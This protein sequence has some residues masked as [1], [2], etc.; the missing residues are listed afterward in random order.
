M[1]MLLALAPFAIAGSILPT[2][3]IMVTTLLGTSRPVT[4]AAAFI[5]G[6]VA[7]RT[8]LGLIVLFAIPL[9]ESDS[10]RLDSGAWDARF[11]IAFGLSLAGLAVFAATRRATSEQAGWLSRVERVRPRTAFLVGAT[12]TA[13]PGAQYAYFL[14][15]AAVILDMAGGR[16][17]EAA[18]LLLF[19]AALQWML[20]LPI[21]LYALFPHRAA[22]MLQRLRTFLSAHGQHIV[23][24]L[25]GVAGIYLTVTGISQLIG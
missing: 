25:L 11:V 22:I 14:G 21:L 6:N 20:V 24:G 12:V 1:E 13:S 8:I 18:T 7:Y 19:V 5:L 16:A 10:F 17:S 3:T 15:G 9:P 23:A 2:W 4:N